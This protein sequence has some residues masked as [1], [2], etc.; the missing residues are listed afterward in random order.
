MAEFFNNKQ[1]QRE[2]WI[3][4]DVAQSGYLEIQKL[5]EADTFE[6]DNAALAYVTEMAYK[7]NFLA[8]RAFEL[9]AESRKTHPNRPQ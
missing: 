8:K 6:D 3:L 9:I 5:D 1:A 4:A 7:G 2:G